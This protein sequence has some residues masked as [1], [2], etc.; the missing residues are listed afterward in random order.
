M[1]D[2]RRIRRA[3]SRFLRRRDG[4]FDI[5][6]PRERSVPID[7]ENPPMRGPPI[8]VPGGILERETN[9]GGCAHTQSK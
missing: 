6:Q 2:Q 3:L 5:A 8:H 7:A 9:I 1:D 4:G